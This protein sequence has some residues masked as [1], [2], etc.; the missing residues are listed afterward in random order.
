M[1]NAFLQHLVGKEHSEIIRNIVELSVKE[2]DDDEF[3]DH[4]GLVV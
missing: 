1:A 4:Y 3:A 2:I